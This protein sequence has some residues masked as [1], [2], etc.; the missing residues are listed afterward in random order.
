ML[1]IFLLY[2]AYAVCCVICNFAYDIV[3]QRGPAFA[4]AVVRSLFVLI[5]TLKLPKQLTVSVLPQENPKCIRC[6]Q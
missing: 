1:C 5:L 4:T 3:A 2:Y 6:I